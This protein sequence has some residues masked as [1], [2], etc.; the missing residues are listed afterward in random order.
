M[1]QATILNDVGSSLRQCSCSSLSIRHRHR[2]RHPSTLLGRQYGNQIQ[3]QHSIQSQ[4][5][6]N[7]P[8]PKAKIASSL[9][10]GGTHFTA[11]VRPSTLGTPTPFSESHQ[12]V[13]VLDDTS[14]MSRAGYKL[15]LQCKALCSS[16]WP[17]NIRLILLATPTSRGHTNHDSLIYQKRSAANGT[18]RLINGARVSRAG[19]GLSMYEERYSHCQRKRRMRWWNDFETTTF[20]VREVASHL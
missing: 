14:K 16:I 9:C 10:Y 3:D 4:R 8:E 2:E 19:Y 18:V 15:H 20:A 13:P 1:P 12:Q 5:G 6:I 17:E 7:I 11:Y